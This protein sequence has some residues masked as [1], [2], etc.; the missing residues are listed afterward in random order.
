MRGERIRRVALTFSFFLISIPLP[1]HHG[2]SEYDMTKIVT[3]NATVK[4]LQ[5]VNP[6]SLL[7]ITVKDDSGKPSEWQGELPSPNLLTRRGWS[8][9]TLKPGDQVTVIG[10]PAKNGEKGM[11]V[12]KLVFP[13]GHE[14]P[15]TV[16]PPDSSK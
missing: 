15:G 5:F 4:Q 1:A 13:D 10:S 12:K 6:H 3:L 8:R 9:S 11:Q 16:L 2:A 7:T 14:L